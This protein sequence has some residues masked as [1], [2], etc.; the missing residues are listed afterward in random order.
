MPVVADDDEAVTVTICRALPT[1]TGM[2]K[3]GGFGALEVGAGFGVG[4]GVDFG[5]D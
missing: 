5:V 4:F 1:V 3:S 2:P